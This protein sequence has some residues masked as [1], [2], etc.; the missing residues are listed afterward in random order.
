MTG[1]C[2]TDRAPEEP[3]YY[4]CRMPDGYEDPAV[5][6]VEIHAGAP[7]VYYTGMAV[8]VP[9]RML[10]RAQWAGPIG[11]PQDGA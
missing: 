1:L 5:V 8:H 4:W 2:W 6:R 3:G 9:M 7:Q 11:R 10:A